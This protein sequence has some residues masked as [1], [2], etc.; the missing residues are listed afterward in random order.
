M[1]YFVTV[2]GEEHV[3]VVGPDGVTVD[4]EP[5]DAE[6]RGAG[7]G[8]TFSAL[9]GGRSLTLIARRT[10]P[11]EWRVLQEGVP[12]SVEAI[13]E[14]TRHIREMAG[15]EAGPRGPQPVRAPMPGLIVEVEVAEGDRVREG[16]GLVIVEAMKMEN[17]LRAETDAIVRQ[18][19]VDAGEPVEKDQILIEFEQPDA[20]AGRSDDEPDA[21]PADDHGEG[22]HA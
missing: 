4:G 5:V 3:V 21:D 1:K 18:V 16:D 13:D 11:G 22:A 14:R 15:A 17:E 10:A 12:L 7:D 20:A 6:V 19:H 9:V 8:Q 2:K